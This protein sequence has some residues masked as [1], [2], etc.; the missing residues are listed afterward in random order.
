M[1]GI[2]CFRGSIGRT[3]LWGG[4]LPQILE[5]IRAKLLTLPDEVTVYPGHGE[6]TTIGFEKANNPFLR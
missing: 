4:S 3:D 5:S 6:I 2:L 1:P